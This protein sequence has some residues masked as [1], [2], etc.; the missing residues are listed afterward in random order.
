VFWG[1]GTVGQT[2]R[3][4]SKSSVVGVNW[5]GASAL[6]RGR[7]TGLDEVGG[8]IGG[9]HQ[10]CAVSNKTYEEKNVRQDHSG[11]RSRGFS[12]SGGRLRPGVSRH[13]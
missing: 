13:R 2:N 5:E 11:E 3:R 4:L 7:Q 10:S 12:S 9:A 6:R 8:K 1:I